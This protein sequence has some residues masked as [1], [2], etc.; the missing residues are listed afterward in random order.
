MRIVLRYAAAMLL[1]NFIWE[2]AQLPL[3]TLWWTASAREAAFAIFH[4]TAG[5]LLIAAISLALAIAV[6]GRREWPARRFGAVAFAAVAFGVAY[7]GFSE[8]LNIH[9]RQSWAYSAWMP[10]IPGIGIGFSPLMQWLLIPALGIG[11]AR[12]RTA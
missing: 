12:R 11:W 1:L 3:Y 8:W 9:V 7:T 4:C 5:D 6:F 10:I 2:V